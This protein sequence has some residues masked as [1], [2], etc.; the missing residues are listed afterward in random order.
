MKLFDIR[1]F[2]LLVLLAS[3]SFGQSRSISLEEF[4][5]VELV[6]NTFLSENPYTENTEIQLFK[7]KSTKVESSRKVFCKYLSVEHSHCKWEYTE[8]GKTTFNEEILHGNAMS[9]RTEDGSWITS[10]AIRI[11]HLFK[12]QKNYATDK[13]FFVGEAEIDGMKCR[14]FSKESV[15]IDSTKQERVSK[16]PTENRKIWIGP[17]GNYMRTEVRWTYSRDGDI[18]SNSTFAYPKDLKIEAPIK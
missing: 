9:R 17:E 16:A 1:V 18:H 8:D 11:G 3:T 14:V 15:K 4:D 12:R 7:K 6:A 10:R 13:Y 2:A 5:S